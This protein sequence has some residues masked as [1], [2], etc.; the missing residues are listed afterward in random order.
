MPSTAASEATPAAAHMPLSPTTSGTRARCCR[1][2]CL[3]GRATLIRVQS[4]VTDETVPRRR[5]CAVWTV[6]SVTVLC[7]PQSIRRRFF[8]AVDDDDVYGAS[9]GLELQPELLLDR[10]ED[11]RTG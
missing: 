1:P 3:R 10:G 7:E 5:F 2:R 8:R 9:S 11:G 4:T 6:P